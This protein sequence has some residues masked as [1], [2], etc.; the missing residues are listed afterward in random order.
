MGVSITQL[1]DITGWECC[2]RDID[3]SEIFYIQPLHNADS[4]PNHRILYVGSADELNCCENKP[5]NFCCV[6]S[7]SK[8]ICPE[9]NQIFAPLQMSEGEALQTLLDALEEQTYIDQCSLKLYQA[10]N[11]HNG[12]QHILDVGV[13]ILG[14]PILL[15]DHSFKLLGCGAPENT[16]SRFYVETKKRGYFPSDYIFGEIA[17][18]TEV[19]RQIYNS[20]K[21]QVFTYAPDQSCYISFKVEGISA[22]IGFATL[23]ESNHRFSKTDPTIFGVLCKVLSAEVRASIQTSERFTHKYEYILTEILD[24]TLHEDQIPERLEQFNLHLKQNLYLMVAVF[25][26]REEYKRYYL[27]F[28]RD[29][30]ERTIPGSICC[31][32]H[33]TIV[34]LISSAQALD[35]RIF[36]EELERCLSKNH[37]VAGLSNRFQ[38]ISEMPHAYRQALLAVNSRTHIETPCTLYRYQDY[39]WYHMLDL[40]HQDQ[41][42]HDLLLPAYLN[43]REYDQENGTTYAET[44][45]IYLDTGYNVNQTARLLNVH[46]NTVDYRI[47]RA[48]ELFDLDLNNGA[49][50]FQLALSYRIADYY[51]ES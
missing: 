42:L 19:H 2:G 26:S 23:L 7:D 35:F 14:N 40:A 3:H 31:L 22:P 43:M 17:P 25:S 37:L 48:K 33:T 5:Q 51:R 21:P 47:N 27:E 38:R 16:T 50:L 39:G 44:V 46:R 34:S 29:Q 10:L 13:E 15:I 6:H 32:Y 8:P 41:T 36:R 30:I 18:D 49:Q 11:G 4:M 24:Q 9:V 1:S 45:R 12:I 28:A 20:D